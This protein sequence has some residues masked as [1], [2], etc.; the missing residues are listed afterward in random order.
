MSSNANTRSDTTVVIT[1]T[2]EAP[3]DCISQKIIDELERRTSA[4]VETPSSLGDA[5]T[6][7]TPPD[8]TT[9]IWYPTD[10][11]GVPTGEAWVYNASTGSWGSTAPPE[12]DE[13][14][15]GSAGSN[16]ITEDSEGCWQVLTNDVRNAMSDLIPEISNDSG[17]IIVLGADGGWFVDATDVPFISTDSGNQITLGGDLGLF[18]P[19]PTSTGTRYGELYGSSITVTNPGAGVYAVVEVD[20][21]GGSNGMTASV[22]SNY[23]SPSVSGPVVAIASLTVTGG[24]N[25]NIA[26]AFEVDGSTVAK[27]EQVQHLPAGASD[28]ANISL[29]AILNLTAGEE[30]K[31]I[32]ADLDSA[33]N[34]VVEKINFFLKDA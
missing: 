27:S 22:G 7:A 4:S 15:L 21:L 2:D 5:V 26:A 19:A 20:Q 17:N 6:S 30:V 1:Y 23:I 32:V 28:T 16:L 25:N 10:A 11:N 13:V 8:D 14:C 24:T 29:S 12:I 33:T 31:V 9:K 18:V 3:G 34:V